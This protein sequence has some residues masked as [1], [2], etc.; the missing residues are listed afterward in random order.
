VLPA[1]AGSGTFF[2]SIFSLNDDVYMHCQLRPAVDHYFSSIFSLNDKVFMYY[3][4]LTCETIFR[5][6]LTDWLGG[7]PKH[8]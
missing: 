4:A 3:Q 2:S 1:V 7:C 6:S 5:K 8:P